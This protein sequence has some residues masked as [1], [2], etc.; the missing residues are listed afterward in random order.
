MTIGQSLFTDDAD[1]APLSYSPELLMVVVVSISALHMIAPD[2]WVPVTLVSYRNSLTRKRTYFLAMLV[3]LTHGVSSVVL[4]LVIAAI[5]SLFLPVAY[6]RLFSVLLLVAIAA[7]I[8]LNSIRES[9]E[10]E[11][12]ESASLLVSVI[13]D[14][15]LVPFILIAGTFGAAYS[16]FMMAAFVVAASISLVVVVVLSLRGL[17]KALAGIKPQTVDAVVAGALVAMAAFIYFIG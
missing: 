9:R 7:Y 6:I 15:A 17:E 8:I 5:G 16:Y 2:H 12:I 14:P 4:S 10:S 13:P 3:G 1:G 11:G